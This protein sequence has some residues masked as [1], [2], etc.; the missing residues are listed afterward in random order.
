MRPTR[1]AALLGAAILPGVAILLGG[2]MLAACASQSDRFYTL[3]PMPDSAPAPRAA[4]TTQVV[5]SISDPAVV[6]RRAMVLDTPGNQVTILEH[7]RWAAPISDLIAQ[8]LAGDIERR[9][10][11]VMVAVR[12]F[13]SS[14]VKIRIDISELSAR[15]AGN[16]TLEA[17]WRIADAESKSDLVG[18]ETFTAP[19]ASGD[20]AAVA[21]AFSVTVS[22]LADRLAEKL[23]AR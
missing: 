12:G 3:S 16:A 8:T 7:E 6:D 14:T 9:R 2:A 20:Y 21:H 4:F 11:D 10:P 5:L 18:S 22:S 17:H 23:P 15:A 1:P 13:G 19:I